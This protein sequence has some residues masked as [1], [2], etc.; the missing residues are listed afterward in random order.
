[1]KVKGL[2]NSEEE[3]N[4]TVLFTRLSKIDFAEYG[5]GH[6][7]FNKPPPRKHQEKHCYDANIK[8]VHMFAE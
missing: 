7:E 1:M 8:D 5:H 2:S 6:T 3:K 4:L